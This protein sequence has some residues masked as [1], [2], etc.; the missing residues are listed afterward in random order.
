M[1]KTYKSAMP[2]SL[3]GLPV[4]YRIEHR[5]GGET[6]ILSYRSEGKMVYEGK[7]VRVRDWEEMTKHCFEPEP[8]SALM[9][10]A[11]VDKTNAIEK[12]CVGLVGDEILAKKSLGEKERAEFLESRRERRRNPYLPLGILI[13]AEREKYLK[14]SVT[15]NPPG[16]DIVE[17][18]KRAINR[19]LRHEGYKP[20][21]SVVPS[22]CAKWLY[23]LSAHEQKATISAMKYFFSIQQ[24]LDSAVENPWSACKIIEGRKPESYKSLVQKHIEKKSLT[25]GQC[26]EIINRC[27]ESCRSGKANNTEFAVLLFLTMLINA[28]ELCGLYFSDFCYMEAYRSRLKLHIER[29]YSKKDKKHSKYYQLQTIQKKYQTRWIPVSHLVREY[30]EALRKERVGTG[31]ESEDISGK[32]LFCNTNKM[33]HMTPDDLEKKVSDYMKPWIPAV[34]SGAK[35]V[36]PIKAISLLQNTAEQHMRKGGYEEEEIRRMKGLAP[37]LISAKSYQ[38]FTNEPELNKLGAMVD[39][40]ISDASNYHP[41]DSQPYRYKRK[42]LLPDAPGGKT[43]AHITF[44]IPKDCSEEQIQQGAILGL[45][46][47]YGFSAE[48][49]H[50]I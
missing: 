30:Y 14:S 39:R 12:F 13:L 7:P 36:K 27:L 48:I 5:S 50:T 26:E 16:V 3:Y 15:G 17:D 10:E 46:A 8:R 24:A 11:L 9:L 21:S 35:G 1:E 42:E 23:S 29:T 25:D 40:W 20:W 45:L 49:K 32:P 33:R 28:E 44:E 31:T 41:A 43:F 18:R 38:D 4:Y 6:L 22:H 47:R 37:I 19:I 34:I 2:G